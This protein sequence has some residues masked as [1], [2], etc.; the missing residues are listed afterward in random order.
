[1][2]Q[3]GSQVNSF[4]LDKDFISTKYPSA[5][6]RYTTT[7]VGARENNAAERILDIVLAA[8]LLI[9]FSPVFLLIA[10]AVKIQDGGPALFAQSRIGQD[11]KTFRCLKFRSMVLNAE[12]R[13]EALLANDPVAREEWERDHKLRHD[14]RITWLG[15]FLRK[16]SLDELPQL[17]NVLNGQMSLVGPRPIVA[18][19]IKR[20][21]RRFDAYCQVRPGITGLWQVGGRNDVSY[22]RRIAY[23]VLYVRDR[24]PQLY[25]AILFRTIPAVLL[26]SGSY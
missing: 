19:E 12:A 13:L 4:C 7:L 24:S 2:S 5:T 6:T 3:I 22:R 1:M 11:G 8:A 20:Y 14:P 26:R 9:V 23:D 18:A 16:S 17:I 10:I 15:R 21:G 25:V